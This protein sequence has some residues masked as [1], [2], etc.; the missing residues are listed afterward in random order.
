MIGILLGNLVLNKFKKMVFFYTW[1]KF[2]DFFE[3]IWIF[4][5]FLTILK[6]TMA[7][8]FKGYN[9]EISPSITWKHLQSNVEF[10]YEKI[11]NSRIS[12]V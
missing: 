6:F 12:M 5:Y 9:Y 8:S 1:N 11:K 7:K 10:C 3:Y 2:I 4:Q